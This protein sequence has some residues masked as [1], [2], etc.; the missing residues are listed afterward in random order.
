MGANLGQTNDNDDVQLKGGTDQTLIGNSGD[1]L[2]VDGSGVTQPIS[3]TVTANAGTGTFAI[4]AAALPLP[5]G[6]STAALQ[7]TGNTS[8]SSIDTK[9][10][11][12]GQALAAASTP[13]V[14]TAAQITTLTPLTSVT[15]TQ[16]TGTNL[17]TV[18]DNFPAVQTV[19]P[20]DT[21]P[22]TQSITTVDA[23]TS[24]L[25]GANGQVFYFGTPTAGSAATYA[26]TGIS[27]VAVQANILGG[28]GTL[29]VEA[30]MDGGSFWFRPNVSQTA[31]QNYTNSFTN[32]FSATINVASMSHIRVRAITSWSGTGT[33]VVRESPNVRIL[34]IGEALPTGANTIGSLANITGTISLPTGASTAANQATANTSLAT[35]AG[36]L[37]LAQGSTTSGQ[38]GNLVQGA[39]S[40]A[41]PT[42]TTGQTDPLSLTL[43]GGLRVDGSNVTQPVSAAS[44]PLPT[45]AATSSLQTTANITLAA[46]DAGIPAALGQTT[47]S[48]SMP[49]TLAS[50]QTALATT[51]IPVD[52]IRQTFSAAVNGLVSGT[53]ATDI[54][55]ITGSGTKTI[56]VL[57]I[58]LSGTQTLSASVNVFLV[59]RSSANT[60]GTSTTLTLVPHD[61]NNSAATATVRSYTVNPTVLGT[62]VGSL[63]TERLTIPAPAALIDDDIVWSFGDRP[64]QAIVLR[65]TAEVLAINLA[66][67][68]V[69][70]SSLDISIE[71]T[72]E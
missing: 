57:R 64:G 33:I 30:S 10:P 50:D 12:L 18:V 48:A 68:T 54:F 60:G 25:T 56:R 72:E 1:K 28:G 59:K 62:T 37:T 65:G 35:I 3:G 32:P 6:A 41:A 36:T 44:L 39:V 5:S 14:L 43:A 15:V 22:A 52:G 61:S 29:V 51:A 27:T 71:F 31:T 2:R 9:T 63:R 17:H 42:Y 7:T 46:I 20:S 47:M 55:T 16:A 40:T 4:S 38:T 11:A 69:A 67:T 21:A 45:G 70:G 19:L 53:A 34:A 58:Q 24:S 26:L 13:V 49:V 23:G 8:L 66:G